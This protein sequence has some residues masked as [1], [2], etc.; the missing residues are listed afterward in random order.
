[1][2]YAVSLS[3]SDG[4]TLCRHVRSTIRDER[5]RSH[6]M[7]RSSGRATAVTDLDRIIDRDNAR[8]L[9]VGTIKVGVGARC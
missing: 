1:M 5:V 8:D 6:R 7:K 4:T 3:L 9:A 2:D